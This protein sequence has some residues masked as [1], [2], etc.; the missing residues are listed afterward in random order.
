MPVSPPE[1]AEV[2]LWQDASIFTLVD[3]LIGSA[4]RRV[5]VEMYELGRAEVVQA[6]AAATARG[7]DVRVITDPTVKAS[8]DS[9][10]KLNSLH[11]PERAYPVDDTRH[12]IDHVKL[13][14]ADGEAAVGGMNWG[15]H[16]DR[17][18][19]YLL[20]T[21]VTVDVD[22]LVRIFDQDWDLARGHP[23]PVPAAAGAVAQTAPRA[24]IP[25]T[26]R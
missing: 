8:R 3:R 2:R 10:A 7:D 17:N 25:G 26:L 11:V 9:A 24:A 18:H 19:D 1:N 21:S 14:V 20:E 15:R 6:L 22:R 16:S 4:H 23:S 5:M 13:L 12:Q